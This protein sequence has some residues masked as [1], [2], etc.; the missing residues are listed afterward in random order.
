MSAEFPD[1]EPPMGKP[2]QWVRTLLPVVLLALCIGSLF[3]HPQTWRVWVAIAGCVCAFAWLYK[4]HIASSGLPGAAG[5]LRRTK[6]CEPDEKY[7][8]MWSRNGWLAL[9]GVLCILGTIAALVAYK[10]PWGNYVLYAI[11]GYVPMRNLVWAFQ[12]K[13][14][15]GSFTDPGVNPPRDRLTISRPR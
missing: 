5:N 3:G 6:F 8:E 7:R 11:L 12:R 9:I 4:Q 14:E 15:G 2:P 10:L 13:L 1:E